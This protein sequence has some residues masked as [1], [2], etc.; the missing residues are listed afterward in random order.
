MSNE[1]KGVGNSY[2][3][4]FWEYDPRV[5]RR[6]N[7]DPKPT[8]GISEYSA[9]GNSPI[10]FSDPLGDTLT[11]PQLRDALKIASG[12]VKDALKNKRGLYAA[13]TNGRLMGE[14]QKYA[15]KNNLNLGDFAE[16]SEAISGYHNGLGTIA[17]VNQGEYEKLDR[18]VINAPGLNSKQALSV[19][20]G[21]MREYEGDLAAR[22]KM[23]LGAVTIVT[24]T[25]LFPNVGAGPKG[26]LI[27]FENELGGLKYTNTTMGR[28]LDPTRTVNPSEINRAIKMTPYADPQGAV[29]ASAYYMPILR[30]GNQ[31]NLKVVYS[32]ESNTVFHFHYSRQAMGPLPKIKK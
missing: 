11:N 15:E 8:V 7:L 4:E 18:S 25:G 27:K 12:E 29:G 31:Y 23:S 17:M 30:N 22:M 16:L 14:A 5:G 2:T 28:M 32:R 19:S 24:T 20:I 26:P 13:G 9:F 6:W 3:A 10:Q 1:I 21:L